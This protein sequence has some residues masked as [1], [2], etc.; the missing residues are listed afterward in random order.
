MAV[1]LAALKGAIRGSGPSRMGEIFD[2]Y[3]DG[4]AQR[5]GTAISPW[6]TQRSEVRQQLTAADTAT[7]ISDSVEAYFLLKLSGLTKPQRSQV[8]ASCGN[9]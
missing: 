3:F 2:K 4:G 7:K 8:L 1:L 6:L 5:A 9:T